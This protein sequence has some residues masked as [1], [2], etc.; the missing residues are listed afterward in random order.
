MTTKMMSEAEMKEFSRPRSRT[1]II[2]LYDGYDEKM[3]P[4][5][6]DTMRFQYMG[7]FPG[8]VKAIGASFRFFVCLRPKLKDD[9]WRV[10][11]V[12]LK[13]DTKYRY[14]LYMKVN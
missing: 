12:A 3:D 10:V 1:E 5:K 8:Y 11:K 4:R 6:F 9:T 2:K 7:T 13:G 14:R